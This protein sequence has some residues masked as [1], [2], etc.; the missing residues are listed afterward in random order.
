MNHLL[1]VCHGSDVPLVVAEHWRLV[2][3]LGLDGV[4]LAIGRTPVRDV[5]KALGADRIVGAFAGASRH[6]GLTLAEAGAD[7]VAFGPA[8]ET[9]LLGDEARAADDLF[10][11]WSQMIEVPSVAEGGLAEADALRLS[12]L[13][14]FLVPDRRLWDDRDP[15]ARIAAFAT[16]LR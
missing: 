6:K 4:H 11:W 2:E 15:V 10:E 7:Y 14:D 12:A 9:G 13:A 8:G 3:P 1:P 5:R 16:T